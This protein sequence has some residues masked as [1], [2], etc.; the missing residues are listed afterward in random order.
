MTRF[1]VAAFLALGLAAATGRIS[2]SSELGGLADAAPRPASAPLAAVQPTEPLR[3]GESNSTDAADETPLAH[4]V[5]VAV[6]STVEFALTL[7]NTTEKRLEVAFPDGFTHDV[8]VFDAAGHEVWRWSNGRLFTQSLRTRMLGGSE[9]YVL[10][11][12]WK[13]EGRRGIFTAV[14]ELRSSNFPVTEKLTFR[15][16]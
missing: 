9:S 2:H 16:P 7:T 11:E 5:E 10:S 15:I 14:V 4:E 13:P 3:A 8:T 1:I 12:R 6:G